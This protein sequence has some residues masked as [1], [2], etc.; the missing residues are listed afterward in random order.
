MAVVSNQQRQ[1]FMDCLREKKYHVMVQRLSLQETHPQ[2][3]DKF[4]S[5]F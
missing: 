1:A 2:V 5:L 4:E 3:H